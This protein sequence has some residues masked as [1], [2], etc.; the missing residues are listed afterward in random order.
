MK[1]IRR[2]SNSKMR[3]SQM[4]TKT[5]TSKINRAMKMRITK[6]NKLRMKNRKNNLKFYPNLEL[7]TQ[8]ISNLAV[9]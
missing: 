6:S 3:M 9:F 1:R 8:N 5:P 2:K 7:L 4:K